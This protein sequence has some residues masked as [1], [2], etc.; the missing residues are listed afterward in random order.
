MTSPK[1]KARVIEMDDLPVD[2]STKAGTVG[3]TLFVLFIN[4]NTVEIA[5]T[6]VLAAL[7]A[8]VS[9]TVSLTLKMLVQRFRKK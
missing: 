2:G 3:G 1:K 7:G 4:L 5:K 8:A 9:F 6:V